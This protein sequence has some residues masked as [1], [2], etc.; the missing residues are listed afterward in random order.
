MDA[1]ID[2]LKED[3]KKVYHSKIQTTKDIE[4]FAKKIK[5]SN[6]TLRRFLGRIKSES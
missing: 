2:R 5:I 4:E 1:E 3:F 6:S